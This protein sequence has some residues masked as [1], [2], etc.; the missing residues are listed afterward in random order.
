MN[1]LIFDVKEF[2]IRDGEG[3]RTT[4]FFKGCP[5][6]CAWCHNPEGLSPT[7]ELWA[8][9]ARCRECGLCR[10]PCEHEDCKPFGRCLHICPQDLV[11]QVGKYYTPQELAAR[12]RRQKPMFDAMGGGVTLS[13]G[14]PLLQADFCAELLGELGGDLHKTLETSGYASQ[15]DFERIIHLCDFVIMDIK[16][17][18]AAEHK[19]YTGVSN[20]PILRNARLLMESGVP[21]VFRTP[22]I[23]QITDT[24]KNL[25]AILDFVGDSPWETLPY[26]GLAGAKYP[27]LGREFPYDAT[28]KTENKGEQI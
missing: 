13:G 25:A 2:S 16:L 7:P 1:G 20:E 26:N 14:E 5:L 17:M 24:E 9:S 21:F 19:Q 15:R 28:I 4:V 12:L 22:L 10:K 6:R 3:I 18:D 27:M 23:P 8:D 11:R